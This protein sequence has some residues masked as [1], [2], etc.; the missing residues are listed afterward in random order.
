MEEERRRLE[1]ERRRELFE[2]ENK[3]KED[4]N[5]RRYEEYLRFQQQEQ[6]KQ[7]QQ[8]EQMKQNEYWRQMEIQRQNYLNQQQQ[9]QQQQLQQQQ[10]QLQQQ[11]YQQMYTKTTMYQPVTTTTTYV[12]PQPQP[13]VTVTKTVKTET[14]RSKFPITRLIITVVRCRRL[15]KKDL[16]KSDPYVVVMH[17]QTRQKT[18]WLKNTQNPVYNHDF[19]FRGVL[20]QDEIV[21]NVFDHTLSGKDHFQGE[22]RLNKNDFVT[23]AEGWF[24]LQSRQGR[25]DR[26][27]GDI[28]LRFNL[29]YQ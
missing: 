24:P 10:Q 9:L 15:V 18:T 29:Q 14:K 7:R 6:E 26:V 20:E 2:L 28:L 5:R 17:N 8:E 19:E 27:H 22:I 21:V 12:Q 1:E 4:E 23:G 13:Q 16:S 11:M 25:Y 3:K